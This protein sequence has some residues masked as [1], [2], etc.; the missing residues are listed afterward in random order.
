MGNGM[1]I[2]QELPQN[3]NIATEPERQYEK[4]RGRKRETNMIELMMNM[5]YIVLDRIITIWLLLLLV[6]R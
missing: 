4:E 5:Q 1:N 2:K 6:E 3:P